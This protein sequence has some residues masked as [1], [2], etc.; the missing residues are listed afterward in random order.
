MPSPET[1]TSANIKRAPDS[2]PVVLRLVPAEI[3][4][5]TSRHTEDV[6]VI[7]GA[8]PRRLS[9][10]ARKWIAEARERARPR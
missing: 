1:P 9:D 5:S 10:D 8:P 2:R 3:N 4:S 6:A 7:P